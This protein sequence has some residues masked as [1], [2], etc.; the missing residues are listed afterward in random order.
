MKG[1]F[2]SILLSC[3][4]FT[5]LSQEIQTPASTLNK[6][7]PGIYQFWE[8]FIN[9]VPFIKD[10]F[11][12]TTNYYI[13]EEKDS[14]IKNYNY[15]F[16]DSTIKHKKAFGF[17]DGKNMYVEDIL[18]RHFIN[19]GNKQQFL[20]MNYIGRFPFIVINRKTV[21]IGGEPITMVAGVIDALISQP[22]EEIWYF[23]KKG[24][25]LQAT[26]QAIGY[27]LI[28]D[29]DLRQEYIAEKKYNNQIYKKYLLKM[30][31]RYPY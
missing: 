8:E 12:V 15:K 3:I 16:L 24:S 21:F 28:K 5:A 29:K 23:N 4:T 11:T 17:F 1:P 26:T 19:I 31:E 6:L 7:K 2:F 22:K 30:N 9:N 10:P 27:L 14:V 18:T 13:T 25:F 20:K